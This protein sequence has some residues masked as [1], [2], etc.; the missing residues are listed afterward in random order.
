MR[1]TEKNFYEWK[2]KNVVKIVIVEGCKA[3][4]HTGWQPDWLQKYRPLAA[5]LMLACSFDTVTQC[6]R[7]HHNQRIAWHHGSINL[8]CGLITTSNKRLESLMFSY[9]CFFTHPFLR[10]HNIPSTT[11]D[12]YN[13]NICLWLCMSGCKLTRNI[14]FRYL[15]LQVSVIKYKCMSTQVWAFPYKQHK[16]QIWAP[17]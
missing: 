3:T 17:Y 7:P 15:W 6:T 16:M 4:G 14:H 12:S 11:C 5:G 1:F 2:Y 8:I 9:S 10:Q 13:Y